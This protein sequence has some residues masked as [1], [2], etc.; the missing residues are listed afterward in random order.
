MDNEDESNPIAQNDSAN[1]DHSI[2]VPSTHTIH[3]ITSPVSSLSQSL[4]NIP[5][6]TNSALVNENSSN[7][8]NNN[9]DNS[10][11]DD[12]HLAKQYKYNTSVHSIPLASSSSSRATHTNPLNNHQLMTT[13]NANAFHTSGNDFM[14]LDG[15]GI[16]YASIDIAGS[17][18]SS[19]VSTSAPSVISTDEQND[20]LRATKAME[21]G[22]MVSAASAAMISPHSTSS[23][24][25][26]VAHIA[27][28]VSHQT[29]YSTSPLPIQQPTAIS[30]A[31]YLPYGDAYYTTG[32]SIP[33]NQI[34][35]SYNNQDSY[36]I[37]AINDAKQKSRR[38]S[39]YRKSQKE[40]S[41]GLCV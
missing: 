20:H 3:S 1:S 21:P 8:N 38:Q 23:S 31:Q 25:S 35:P 33:W 37:P 12:D 24:A 34:Q 19:M 41:Y 9:A 4:I 15:Q 22:M 27:N 39:L 18:S 7:N 16:D 14:G 13:K 17:S 26:S 6:T 10:T 28:Q 29:M 30:I 5:N 11:T 2:S 36:S 40:R 32:Q